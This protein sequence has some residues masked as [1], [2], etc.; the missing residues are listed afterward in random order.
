MTYHIYG[1][2]GDIMKK[3]FYILFTWIIIG[4]TIAGVHGEN[5]RIGNIWT[6]NILTSLN[7]SDLKYH[8]EPEI[9]PTIYV[10]IL[11]EDPYQNDVIIEIKSIDDENILWRSQVIPIPPKN[12][13]NIGK[14]VSAKLNLKKFGPNN[15]H[16]TLLNKDGKVITSGKGT[17]YIANPIDIVNIT[18]MESYV[19]ESEPDVEV[20]NSQWFSILLKNNNYSKSDYNVKVWIAVVS[21]DFN[22]DASK[23]HENN[24]KILYYGESNSKSIYIPKDGMF[25]VHFKIPKITHN[26]DRIKVQ[27]HMDIYGAHEYADGSAYTNIEIIDKYSVKHERNIK[28]K[29]FI[30]PISVDNF[31]VVT[32]INELAIVDIL[33]EYN[34]RSSIIDPE[35]NKVLSNYI[36]YKDQQHLPRA[37]L[38]EGP[39]LSVVKLTLKNNFEDKING[40]IS[41]KSSTDKNTLNVSLDGFETKDIYIPV[42]VNHSENNMNLSICFIDTY[43]YSI[44]KN[45][46]VKPIEVP[47]VR[48]EKIALH[49]GDNKYLNINNDYINMLNRKNYTLKITIRNYYNK[50]LS[51]NLTLD[52]GN[53]NEN[54]VKC[55][56]RVPFHLRPHEEKI[57]DLPILFDIPA[58]ED[59]KFTL[60]VNDAL[61]FYSKMVHFN[62]QNI[63]ASIEYTGPNRPKVIIAN[64]KPIYKSFPVAGYKNKFTVVYKNPLDEDVEFKTW[65]KVI[66][67]DGTIEA[68]TSKKVVFLPSKDEKSVD[69]EIKFSSGFYGM[70]QIYVLPIDK[71]YNAS[72]ITPVLTESI[73]VI[74]PLSIINMNYNNSMAY[75]EVAFN[76]KTPY[77][78][79]VSYNYWFEL[80]T[81]NKTIFKSE[82]YTETIYPN[83]INN[84]IRLKLID[85]NDTN[86]TLRMYIEIPNFVMINKKY[87]PII[88]TKHIPIN[89]SKNTTEINN[90]S[91]LENNT[92]VSNL[93]G[94]S[95]KNNSDS[96]TKSSEDNPSKNPLNTPSST[97]ENNNESNN[98]S[99]ESTNGGIIEMIYSTISGIVGSIFSLFGF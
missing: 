76:N 11:N 52:I 94:D 42:L 48:I 54:I 93:T 87:Y 68:L 71:Y 7:G 69:F 79:R 3:I 61:T 58:K 38:K 17:I 85:V 23:Y 57:I 10:E 41:I 72:N 4:A 55:P 21:Q 82:T 16:I 30:Y 26:S 86:S 53:L 29:S 8:I 81:N 9:I 32:N 6:S 59:I 83:S 15:I 60:E 27:V 80:E 89:N 65:I 64:N 47:V 51:G 36:H 96:I 67:E 84:K 35:L 56:L 95:L 49:C 12:P 73:N 92:I 77:P 5:V 45:L 13:R 88:I 50:E 28:S 2:K 20:C 18:C 31:E 78:D 66:K 43:E 75:A 24:D 34:I 98:T 63:D 33:K 39:Y 70:L 90:E 97:V 74:G 91:L 25:E 44:T 40:V 46:N 22:D 62:V 99:E 14:V 37:Y 19:N 1:D